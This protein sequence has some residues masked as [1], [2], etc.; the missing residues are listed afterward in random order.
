MQAPTGGGGDGSVA[1]S[2][3][4]APCHGT[5]RRSRLGAAT[6]SVPVPAVLTTARAVTAAAAA[7][8]AGRSLGAS[9]A[10]KLF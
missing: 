7:A 5:S 2:P 4:V 9:D 10:L 8:A 6:I 1:A 3:A